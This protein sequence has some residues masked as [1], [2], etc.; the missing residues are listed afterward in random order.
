MSDDFE[1]DLGGFTKTL[2]HVAK[3]AALTAGGGA[4]FAAGSTA[5]SQFV[6][7]GLTAALPS[8]PGA[9]VI[10]PTV[11]CAFGAWKLASMI[12]GRN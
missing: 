1:K 9:L 10:I 7:A 5:A 2:G 4:G 12:F 3:G 11:L 6:A 8:G